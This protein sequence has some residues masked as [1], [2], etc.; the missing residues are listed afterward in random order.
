MDLQDSLS[1]R[2]GT[3]TAF[4][5]EC[6]AQNAFPVNISA[7]VLV[8]VT[9]IIAVIVTSIATMWLVYNIQPL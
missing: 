3:G 4:H 2:G 6:R 5:L 9:V 8:G 7:I 1:K